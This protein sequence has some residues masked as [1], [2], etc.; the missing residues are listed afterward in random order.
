LFL[1]RIL[2]ITLALLLGGCAAFKQ[3]PTE[4]RPAQS[5]SV[6]FALNGRISIKHLDKRDSAGLRWVHQ[7][8]TDEILLLNPLGQT[9][10]RVYSDTRLESRM[11]TLDDGNKHYKNTDAESLME[12]V[13]GWHL[14]L[15]DLHL[16]VLGLPA[17]DGSAQIERDA[18]GRVSVLHKDNW[19]VTYLEYADD[20]VDALPRR[21]KLNHEDLQVTL[22]LDEWDWHP[23]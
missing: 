10:A 4:P 11:A 21:M 23:Q 12:E 17:V 3:A 1:T 2:P 19:E 6:P 14:P 5:D 15:S 18:K 16:W 22:L 13:M 7:A 8:Q 20:K 9:A